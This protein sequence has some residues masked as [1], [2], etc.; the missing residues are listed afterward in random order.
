MKGRICCK[1]IR[2]KKIN[3]STKQGIPDQGMTRKIS[4]NGAF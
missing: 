1:Q 2:G 3:Y 4:Y